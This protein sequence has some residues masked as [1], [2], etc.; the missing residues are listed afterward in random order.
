MEAVTPEHLAVGAFDVVFVTQMCGYSNLPERIAAVG[1]PAICLEPHRGFH[2][3]HAAFNDELRTLGGTVLPA[4][5]PE[6]M[7]ASIRAVRSRRALRGA[8]LLVV[9]PMGHER[10]I[11]MIR[12]FAEGCR[13]RMGLDIVVRDTAELHERTL[14]CGDAAADAELARRGEGGEE[15][16]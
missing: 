15:E 13:E 12:T 5:C 11:A 14:A 1:L 3:Y 10:R 2:A 8:K 7:E 6:E 9:E 16:V 4:Q